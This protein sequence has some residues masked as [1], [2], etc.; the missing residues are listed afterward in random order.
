MISGNDVCFRQPTTIEERLQIAQQFLDDNPTFT[1][2]FAIDLM[3]NNAASSFEA[4]PERLYILQN[5]IIAYKG[6]EGPDEYR[7][8]EVVTW[9]KNNT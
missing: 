7:L 5:G 9:L 3:D 1:I 8:S 2:P 4:S 6:G